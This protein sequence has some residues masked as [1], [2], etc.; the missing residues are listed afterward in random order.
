MSTTSPLTTTAAS[1][2]PG[3]GTS[4]ARADTAA[5]A[6]DIASSNPAQERMVLHT[7]KSEKTASRSRGPQLP[8][9]RQERLDHT[10]RLAEIH[11]AGVALLERVHHLAHVLHAGGAGVS[12]GGRD[13]VLGL[14]FGELLRQK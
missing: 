14:G 1:T 3:C 4:C 13:R 10:A 11:G 6:M 8:C 2:K 12:D 9:P 5:S 7:D